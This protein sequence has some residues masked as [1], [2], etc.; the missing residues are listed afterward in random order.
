MDAV[1]KNIKGNLI[2]LDSSCAR[3]ETALHKIAGKLS[4]KLRQCKGSQDRARIRNSHPHFL[5]GEGEAIT[6]N[7]DKQVG[8]RCMMC[9]KTYLY[10]I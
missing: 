3:L 4:S 10:S 2:T 9:P 6:A 1:N 7:M 5:V 8:V